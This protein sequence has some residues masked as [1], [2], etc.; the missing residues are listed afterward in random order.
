[1]AFVERGL[2]P[3]RI[4]T[5]YLRLPDQELVIL[6]IEDLSEQKMQE[7]TRQENA[8]LQA[9]AV[10]HATNPPLVVPE[11]APVARSGRRV[12]AMVHPSSEAYLITGYASESALQKCRSAGSGIV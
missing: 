5:N 10:C 6:A 7:Q 12:N 2:L 8:R 11:S 3:V 4:S 9:A 1:M